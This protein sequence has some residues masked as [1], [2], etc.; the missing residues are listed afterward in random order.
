MHGGRD[1]GLRVQIGGREG[2]G[3]TTKKKKTKVSPGK[4][5]SKTRGVKTGRGGGKKRYVEKVCKGKVSHQKMAKKGSHELLMGK[6]GGGG[7]QPIGGVGERQKLQCWGGQGKDNRKGK[8]SGKKRG[9]HWGERQVATQKWGG[10]WGENKAGRTKKKAEDGKK[11][12][13]KSI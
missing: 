2:G 3:E 7:S 1:W 5:A 4:G 6:Q 11:D 10:D 8:S 13:D 12:R 9:V